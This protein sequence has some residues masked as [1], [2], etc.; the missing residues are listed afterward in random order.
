M[1]ESQD[2]FMEEGAFELDE[3]QVG[4]DGEG[5]FSYRSA[6]LTIGTELGK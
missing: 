2:N 6:H 5:H 1:W 3:I 4:R